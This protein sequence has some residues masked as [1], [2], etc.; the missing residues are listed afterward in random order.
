MLSG[1]NHPLGV[2][3]IRPATRPTSAT[4]VEAL[5]PSLNAP[6]GVVPAVVLLLV[7]AAGVLVG[8]ATLEKPLGADPGTENTLVAPGAPLGK[9]PLGRP[10]AA[11]MPPLAESVGLTA[12]DTTAVVG[13]DPLAAGAPGMADMAAAWNDWKVLA[14]VGLTAKTIPALQ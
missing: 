12:P 3:S 10:V 14:A 2:Y 6:L 9:A 13:T 8:E 4:R 11:G 5:P 7:V 1:R